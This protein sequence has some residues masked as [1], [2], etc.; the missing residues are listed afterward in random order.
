MSVEFFNL[1]FAFAALSLRYPAVFWRTNHCFAFT[2]SLLLAIIGLQGLL[3]I[4]AT[5]IIV[6]VCWNKKDIAPSLTGLCQGTPVESVEP[7]T[8]FLEPAHFEEPALDLE[9]LSNATALFLSTFGTLF[10]LMLTPCVFDYGIDQFVDRVVALRRSAIFGATAQ[11]VATSDT[12]SIQDGGVCGLKTEGQRSRQRAVIC[13]RVL[14]VLGAICVLA[15]K[16]PILIAS[17]NAFVAE[18]QPL[19]LANIVA[20]VFFFCV[21]FITWFAFCLKP[22]WKFKVTVVF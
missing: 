6:K 5:E 2:F 7:P 15:I 16:M 18:K 14:A 8:N 9:G 21:W 3:E 20:T 4:N 17:G 22:D 10:M 12:A 19:L 11:D 1:L 13:R